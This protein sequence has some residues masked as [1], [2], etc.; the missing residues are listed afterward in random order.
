MVYNPSGR[1]KRIE[2][3]RLLPPG[4]CCVCGGPIGADQI[5]ADLDVHIEWYG[6]LYQ[7]KSCVTEAVSCWD[8]ILPANEEALRQLAEDQNNTIDSL[9]RQMEKKDKVIDGYRSTLDDYRT[10]SPVDDSGSEPSGI[11]PPL[12]VAP[13]AIVDAGYEKLGERARTPDDSGNPNSD[14]LYRE[15][16]SADIEDAIQRASE[17]IAESTGD[18]SKPAPEQR[19]VSVGSSGPLF[20]E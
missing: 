3:G 20:G 5:A 16:E 14:G 13:D 7:C 11:L 19:S 9:R 17:A 4:T 15:D 1:I 6:S 8:D 12:G 18:S 10:V 2:G